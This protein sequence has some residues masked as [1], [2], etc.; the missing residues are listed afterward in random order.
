MGRGKAVKFS[1]SACQATSTERDFG[2]FDSLPINFRLLVNVDNPHLSYYLEF[3]G[4]ETFK[5]FAFARNMSETGATDDMIRLNK[6]EYRLWL[7]LNNKG[8]R[9]PRCC[10]PVV[11]SHLQEHYMAHL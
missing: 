8:M 1:E 7:V 11:R 3:L 9:C 10:L 4:Y 5:E 6:D 2:S